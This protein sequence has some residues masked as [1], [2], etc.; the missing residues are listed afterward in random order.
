MYH[1]IDEF[2]SDWAFESQNTLKLFNALTDESLK[3]EVIPNDRTL[4]SIAWHI[5]NTIGEMMSHTGIDIKPDED[6]DKEPK[7]V[8][9]II[10]V[11]TKLSEQMTHSL[12]E[13]WT[14]ES[15]E[16]VFNMYGENWKG[17]DVLTSLIR[18]EI[19]HRAQMTILMR[20]A[21]LKIPGIYGP[22]KE[23]WEEINK[24]FS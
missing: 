9:Q 11:Y 16:K 7:S 6:K 3:T 23:E 17:R 19:H 1:T 5:T 20:Q 14:N 21:G 4:G 22:S 2:L 10:D 15:L 13:K 24:Q 8:K 12:N 18:H